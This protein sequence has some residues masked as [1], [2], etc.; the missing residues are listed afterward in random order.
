MRYP[1]K[2]RLRCSS[3]GYSVTR[4]ARWELDGDAI[5]DAVRNAEAEGLADR[6]SFSVADVAAPGLSAQFDLVT[7]LEGFH[8]MARPV[9]ALRAVRRSRGCHTLGR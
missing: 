1:W 8:D 7:I 5:A 9:E 6:V 3:I 4:S 2:T